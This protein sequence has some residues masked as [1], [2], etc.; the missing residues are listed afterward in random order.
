MIQPPLD[1]AFWWICAFLVGAC[2]GSFLNVVIY[3]L[4]LG[5]SVNDPKRSFCPGCRKEIPMRRNVPLVSWLWLRGK[6]AECGVKIPARYF[7]VE[8]LTGVLF[9]AVWWVVV[10]RAGPILSTAHAAVL[11]LWALTAVLVAVS[12]IDA[13]HLI[14]PISLSVTGAVMAFAAAG[15]MPQ[16]PD[17]PYWSGVAWDW[18]DG[19]QRS[20]LGGTV[21]FFGLWAVVL[22]GKLAFGRKEIAHEA[23]VAWR[24]EEPKDE[25]GAIVFEMGEERIDWWDLFFRP[26]DRLVIEA[27]SVRVDGVEAT[28]GKVTIRE[29]QIELPD[30]RVV[31]VEDLKALDG[32]AARAVIPREAMG[33]GDVHLM[34]VIGLAFGWSGVLFSLMAGSVFAIVAALLGRVGFGVRLPFGPFLV[35]GAAVWFFGGWRLGEWYLGLLG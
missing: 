11:P 24:L 33:M 29:R 14:I 21:G 35:L 30:G 17:L 16:L 10:E 27:T 26:S 2:I 8:L 7:W 28:A 12:F 6:C 32:T 9:A 31:A 20:L 34:G 13:E 25:E 22:L 3:R 5:L 1:H 19:L 15:L 4:P 23:P 18:K